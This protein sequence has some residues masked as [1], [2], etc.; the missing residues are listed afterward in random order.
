VGIILTI[1]SNTTLPCDATL[2]QMVGTVDNYYWEQD[3]LTTLCTAECFA[4]VQ[5]WNDDVN[6]NCYYDSLVAY[7]KVVDAA[8]VAGRTLDGMNIACLSNQK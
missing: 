2:L 3:N 4:A 6:T 1:H 7:N 5:D 8:S